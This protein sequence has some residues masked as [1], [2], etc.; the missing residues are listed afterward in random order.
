TA[1]GAPG[2]PQTGR[3][4]NGSGPSAGDHTTVSSKRGPNAQGAQRDNASVSAVV[5]RRVEDRSIAFEQFGLP[6]DVSGSQRLPLSSS[7]SGAQSRLLY[8]PMESA[9]PGKRVVPGLES[10]HRKYDDLPGHV[11]RRRAPRISD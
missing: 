11:E 2:K 6:R 4:G 9:F 5:G 3:G 1:A 8:G 7:G 10:R